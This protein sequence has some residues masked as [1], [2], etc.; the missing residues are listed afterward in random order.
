MLKIKVFVWFTVNWLT[1]FYHRNSVGWIHILYFTPGIW[2]RNYFTRFWNCMTK[3]DKVFKSRISK[4]FKGCL[5]Q[6]LLSPLSNT[7]FQIQAKHVTQETCSHLIKNSKLPPIQ[8]EFSQ[9]N[10]ND[11]DIFSVMRYVQ[12]KLPTDRGCS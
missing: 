12:N 6:N 5:P 9:T 11:G 8:N 1:N 7:L 4:F 10:F 3:W 2:A